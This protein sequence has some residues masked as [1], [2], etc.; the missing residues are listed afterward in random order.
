VVGIDLGTV[1][2]AAAA[3]DL[4][5]AG[6]LAASVAPFP[7]PQLVAPGEVGARD[8]L[9]SAVYLPGPELPA[10]ARALPWGTPG[11]VVGALAREQG[12]RVPG[13]LVHS[14][15]SW[16]ANPRADRTAPILPCTE[17]K[18][19]TWCLSR[20]RA[21]GRIASGMVR[22]GTAV[23]TEGGPAVRYLEAQLQNQGGAGAWRRLPL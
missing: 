9:P 20:K 13:R 23:V 18:T 8:L 7:I 4:S 15:K 3:V 10:A 11:E 1:N 17:R 19:I 12:A 16:L 2:S 21:H 22:I 14:A 5:G 6:D